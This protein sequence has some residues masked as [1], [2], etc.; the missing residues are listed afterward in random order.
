MWVVR[1]NDGGL[2]LYENKPIKRYLKWTG[3]GKN[4]VLE[5]IEIDCNL[6]PGVNWTDDEPTEIEII[7][8]S[9]LNL[10]LQEV[11]DAINNYIGHSLD[12]DEDITTYSRREAF[13]E[14]IKW[15]LNRI[16]T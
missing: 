12:I 2:Y 13:K 16:K 14:G 15:M 4:G 5:G 6:L 8:K 1:D 3:S 10:S 11:D 7:K 9:N